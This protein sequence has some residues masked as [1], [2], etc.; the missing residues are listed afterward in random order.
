MKAP[1]QLASHCAAAVAA[2]LV[3]STAAQAG[4]V[5]ATLYYTTFNGGQNVWRVQ[6]I[7]TGNGTAGNGTFTL[8]GDTNIAST[9]GADGIV[10]NP[11]NGQLLVGGQGN[12][13]HQ[14]NPLTGT[15][16]TAIPGVATFHLAVDPGK[17][18]V[19]ASS[20]PGALASVPINPFGAAG[21]VKTLSGN[22]TSI[23][24]L[25][26]APNGTVYYTNAGSGGFGNFGTIDLGTGVT[27]RLLSGVPAAHGM[28]YDPFSSTLILGGSNH[29]SQISLVTNTVIHDLV[30][31]GDTFDQGAVDG[32]G[33][34]FWADNN[35]RFFFLDYST[36]NDVSSAANFMSNEFFK[37]ALDDIAPLIG[38]GGTNPIPEPETYALMLAGLGLLGAV[39]RRRKA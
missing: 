36:T 1:F 3:L 37:S 8:G 32:Q 33:H 26:F 27:T 35:G 23:T 24:S 11:N 9:G 14:V 20:I 30:V 2:T 16:T 21:T 12:A 34:V 25:A 22:D 19:W 7:Y 28:V 18:V 31:P 13:I 10:L 38:A 15:F 4:P 17:N 39:A 5:D 29:I 6:G